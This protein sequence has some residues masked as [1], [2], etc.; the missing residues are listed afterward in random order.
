M[1]V[2]SAIV[3]A[4][5]TAGNPIALF[6]KATA[7]MLGSS[8]ALTSDEIVLFSITGD[9]TETEIS[10]P[11]TEALLKKFQVWAATE[12]VRASVQQ[13]RP[14]T[15]NSLPARVVKQA[16]A[17]VR[18]PQTHRHVLLAHAAKREDR[19]AKRARHQVRYKRDDLAYWVTQLFTPRG[20]PGLL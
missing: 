11:E 6:A 13:P 9:Q 14:P 15:G 5:L 2:T 12:D 10:K 3:L 8:A 7:S 4:A 18:P 17:E 16:R 19:L 20:H 1:F